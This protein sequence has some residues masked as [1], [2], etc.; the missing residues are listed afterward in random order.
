MPAKI[1]NIKAEGKASLQQVVRPLYILFFAVYMNR[2]HSQH[3]YSWPEITFILYV[4]AALAAL[5]HTGH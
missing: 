4:A 5:I 2:S 1:R 3:A